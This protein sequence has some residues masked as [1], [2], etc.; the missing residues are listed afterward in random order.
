MLFIRR[1][2]NN[3][4]WETVK[5]LKKQ[6]FL[7]KNHH[8]IDGI[9]SR[10]GVWIQ[11]LF[12]SWIRSGLAK[13]HGSGSGLSW[14]VWTGSGQQQIGSESLVRDLANMLF[15]PMPWPEELMWIYRPFL[16]LLVLS[17]F[18]KQ[19]FERRCQNMWRFRLIRECIHM[20]IFQNLI[21]GSWT[22][23]LNS[24]WILIPLFY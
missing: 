18:G 8:K 2:L 5:K 7:I 13:Y 15:L 23:N 4:D 21:L 24:F 3:C 10:R 6:K 17:K 1:K 12:F 9:I 19:E 14:D 16:I 22:R 11:D 20:S